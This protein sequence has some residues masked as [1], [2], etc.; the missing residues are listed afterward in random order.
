M[1]LVVYLASGFLYNIWV[2]THLR[3]HISYTSK[4]TNP[5]TKLPI[6]RSLPSLTHYLNNSTHMYTS[7]GIRNSPLP[8]KAAAAKLAQ[9]VQE[10]CHVK[11]HVSF[12]SPVSYV[13]VDQ[14]VMP[15]RRHFTSTPRPQLEAFP[16]P[17]N[18]PS[19]KVTA[20][21]WRHPV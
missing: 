5:S 9:A 10:V 18:A 15:Q 3:V 2:A 16:P 21:A 13:L 19:V 11:K 6:V 1:T 12:A 20:P 14:G 4:N 8:S 7:I 17:V